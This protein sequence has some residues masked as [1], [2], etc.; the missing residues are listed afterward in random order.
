M[1]NKID[2]AFIFVRLQKK[3]ETIE[4]GLSLLSTA[5]TKKG[6]CKGIFIVF[7]K[8]KSML[9]MPTKLENIKVIN[10]IEP[11]INDLLISKTF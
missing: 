9:E 7:E 2:G 10:A 11:I 6:N 5:M 1:Q 8:T 4:K 3:D